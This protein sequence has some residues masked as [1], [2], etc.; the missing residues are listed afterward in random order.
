MLRQQPERDSAASETLPSIGHSSAGAQSHATDILDRITDAFIALDADWC[1]T[2]VSQT[3]AQMLERRPE[4][5]IGRHIW[6]EFPDSVGQPFYNAYHKAFADQTPSEIKEYSP[7]YER[8]FQNR[9]FPSASGLT[10][11]FQDVTERRKTEAALAESQQNFWAIAEAM[12][13]SIVMTRLSDQTIL[14]ANPFVRQLF[15]ATPET[16][17]SQYTSYHFFQNPADRDEIVRLLQRDSYV[18][19]RELAMRR[20]DGTPLW[21]IASFQR[22]TYGGEEV[23]LATQ[24]DITD[25]KR[26]EQER[27]RLLREAQDREAA[28]EESQGQ[29][30]AIAEAIPATLVITRLSDGVVLY[31]NPYARQLY[32]VPSDAD[33]TLYR[34]ADF[35][36]NPAER[37]EISR[38]LSQN[39]FVGTRE[40]AVKRLDGT[41]IWA[42]G[43][44]RRITYGGDEAVLG[45]H[46]DIT[47]R[48]RAEAEQARLADYNRL[49]LES[50]AEGIYGMDM[51]GRCTFINRAAAE[52]IG[53][54]AAEALGQDM[55]ALIHHTRAD[56]SP[57][58]VEECPI[59][60]AFQRGLPCRVETEV[61][62]RQ[63]GS[64]FPAAYSSFPI[65]DGG[66]VIGAVVTFSDITE[67]ISSEHA[68]RQSREE[69][70]ESE[71]R[72][73]LA[74][75][76]GWLGWWHLDLATG[77]YLEFSD[78]CKTHF[79][80][81]AD[82]PPRY[83]DFA[84]SIHPEDR[85]R[86]GLGAEAGAGESR[87]VRRRVPRGVARWE[88][89]LGQRSRHGGVR[90]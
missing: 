1:Y 65:T 31:A 76:G 52:M 75:T 55:H 30:Q 48:R 74:L 59:Y 38:Q 10:V 79:G 33:P 46:Y 70:L 34:A 20:V 78:Q 58:A 37:G 19:P 24:H 45:A 60:K 9:I 25:R 86:V 80:M 72:L 12:P 85:A 11:F 3:A 7:R 15:G 87:G 77:Q 39:S 68:L 21:V 66:E 13:T 42:L 4:D 44:F 67:R 54:T 43:S 35:Y 5:L 36:Q 69:R 14:Y 90:R 40:I 50:T 8:W 81:P 6:T 2:Y 88:R 89:P 17:T 28:L 83:G 16:D 84:V 82:A 23:S 26:A 29:F 57:Y 56:G 61:L 41:P 73:R 71:R 47:D 22:L 18:G 63:D 64:S 49:L 62:W 51:D 27:E 32:G 53:F